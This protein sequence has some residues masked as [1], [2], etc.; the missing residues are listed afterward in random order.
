MSTDLKQDILQAVRKGNCPEYKETSHACWW[1]PCAVF[2]NDD[3]TCKNAALDTSEKLVYKVKPRKIKDKALKI[4][5]KL[6][7][8]SYI[9]MAQVKRGKEI[10]FKEFEGK[11]Q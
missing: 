9:S 7:A 8:D 5:L 6:S 2:E 11:E 1:C 4:A 10:L 3:Y